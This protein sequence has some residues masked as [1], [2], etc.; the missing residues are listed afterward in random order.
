MIPDLVSGTAE[1]FRT[2][3]LAETGVPRVCLRTYLFLWACA[4]A[5]IIVPDQRPST[6]QLLAAC[7]LA[8]EV[9]PEMRL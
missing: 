4:L 6:K 5:N 1:A 2:D 8:I 3:A 9:V 7:T